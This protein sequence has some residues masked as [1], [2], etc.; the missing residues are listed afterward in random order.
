MEAFITSAVAVAIGEIG[1]KTQ[2]LAFVLTA[3]YRKPWPIIFGIIVATT[4]NHALAGALGGWIGALLTPENLRIPLGLSF[5]ILAAWMLKP[6][7]LDDTP[8]AIDRHGPFVATLIAF[9]LAEMGD[10]TQIA[11]IALAAHYQALVPVVLGTTLGM[12]VANVP[13][14]VLGHSLG[15]RIPMRLVNVLAAAVFAVIGAMVLA[16]V[17]LGL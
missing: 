4:V 11:T 3:R 14:V 12:L 8:G 15:H 10:K 13:V 7:K 6:D 17:S 1:D 9:F 16:G 5:L 2:L